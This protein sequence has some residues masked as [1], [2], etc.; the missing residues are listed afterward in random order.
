MRVQAARARRARRCHSKNRKVRF[1]TH[2]DASRALALLRRN[3]SDSIPV[4]SYKCPTCGGWH[5]TSISAWHPATA[6]TS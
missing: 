2:E 1:R 4:R 3:E 6:L 5:L